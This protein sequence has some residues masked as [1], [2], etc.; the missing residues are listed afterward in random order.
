MATAIQGEL[1]A[2][3]QTVGPFSPTSL[4]AFAVKGTW[5]GILSLRISLDGDVDGDFEIAI[6]TANTKRE[7]ANGNQYL[8]E[9]I[10]AGQSVKMVAVQIDSGTAEV[11]FFENQRVSS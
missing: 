5:D 10:R 6:I 1:T 4:G 2:A 3:D 9:L 8:C 11:T 7:D